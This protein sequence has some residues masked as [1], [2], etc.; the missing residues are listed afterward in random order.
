MT[1]LD[2]TDPVPQP[3]VVDVE[4]T[5]RFDRDVIPLIDQ[6][7]R[8]AMRMTGNRADAEDLVQDTMLRAHRGFGS[9]T[10]GTNITA[11]MHRILTNT[12]I[13]GHRMRQR[14]PSEWLTDQPSDWRVA[15]NHPVPAGLRSADVEALEA[16][17][18]DRIVEALQQLPLPSRMAV[19]YADVEGLQYSEIAQIMGTPVG[20]VMSRLH[21]GR[22]KLRISLIDVARER[23]LATPS[24]PDVEKV[25]R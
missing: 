19:Y 5:A 20:T 24:V 25:E 13:N 2:D 18:D 8:A 14:R 1:D 9:F 23:G 7:Y 21:R 11:W 12:F 22:R 10:D 16:L 17:P 4:L 3:V 15:T 6:L